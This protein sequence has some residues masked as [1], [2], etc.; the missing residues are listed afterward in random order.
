VCTRFGRTSAGPR[1]QTIPSGSGGFLFPARVTTGQ[2][3]AGCIYYTDVFEKNQSMQCHFALNCSPRLVLGTAAL[4]AWL[5]EEVG[6][7]V[8]GNKRSDRPGC[9]VNYPSKRGHLAP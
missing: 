9:W 8:R 6:L 4:L 2:L 7:G 5:R 3:I 1:G